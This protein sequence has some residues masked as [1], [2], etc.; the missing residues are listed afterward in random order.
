MHDPT[1]PADYAPFGIQAIDSLI[2]VTYAQRD[3][4]SP[5]EELHAPGAGAVS[6]YDQ[7]GHL[8]GHVLSGGELDAPWAV[9]RA[10][11]SFGDL[12][13]ALLIAN[14]GDGHITALSP[15][16][17]HVL[18]QL[19]DATGAPIVIDG[20]WG[21]VPG[22]SRNAGSRDALYY[23]AGPADEMHG[24]FGTIYAEVVSDGG[25]NDSGTGTG[26]GGGGGGGG[27]Y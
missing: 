9:A 14:F 26:T 19:E 10:P 3:P 17:G 15:I 16:D 25:S 2:Y 13:Q 5:D 11:S 7:T 27:G 12:A 8:V 4:A 20:L 21:L 22:N 24:L 23:T 18:G 1:L 6:V